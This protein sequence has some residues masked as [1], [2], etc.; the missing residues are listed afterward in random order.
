M[1]G[2]VPAIHDLSGGTKNVDARDKPGHDE[3]VAGMA[4]NNPHM[5]L[6]CPQAGEVERISSNNFFKPLSP[7]AQPERLEGAVRSHTADRARPGRP[8]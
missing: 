8:K 1:A 7:L 3:F 2:L 4:M 6:P 5:R